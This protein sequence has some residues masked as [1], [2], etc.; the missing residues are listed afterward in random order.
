MVYADRFEGFG[1]LVASTQMNIKTVH[2][3]G[4]LTE[5]EPLM[6]LSDT[7]CQN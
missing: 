5:G 1:A 4:D 7:Q 2:I 6:T 3:E